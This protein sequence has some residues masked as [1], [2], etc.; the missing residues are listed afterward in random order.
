MEKRANMLI[1]TFIVKFKDD[2]RDKVISLGLDDVVANDIIQFV[3]DYDRLV[4][5]HDAIARPK[6]TKTSIPI[7]SRCSAKLANNEQCTRKRRKDCDFCGTHANSK[8]NGLMT[9]EEEH[10]EF[11]KSS[12]Q[13][14]EISAEDVNGIIYH[15]DSFGNAYNTEDILRGSENPRI[16]GTFTKG[17]ITLL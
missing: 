5:D 2:I 17:I 3:Y 13:K 14:V 1:D 9:N 15:V 6:R 16:I 10:A 4:I 7:A 12:N 11:L 8:P